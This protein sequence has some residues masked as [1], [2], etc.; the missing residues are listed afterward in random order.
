MR[1]RTLLALLPQSAV[2]LAGCSASEGDGDP[3]ETATRTET[4][5]PDTDFDASV[6]FPRG[7]VAGDPVRIEVTVSNSGGDAGDYV[8]TLTRDG[9]DLTSGSARVGPGG[10]ATITLEHAFESAGEYDVAVAGAEATLV[11]FEHSLAFVH[12]AMGDVDTL[13]IEQTVSETGQIDLGEGPTPWELTA[14][15]T[16]GKNFEAETLYTRREDDVVYGSEQIART[17]E[18]WAADGTV[19]VRRTNHT[20]ESVEYHQYPSERPLTTTAL[21]IHGT[22]TE[23]FLSVE[24]TDD[25]YVFVFDPATAEEATALASRT[26]QPGGLRPAEAATEARLE[27]RY[28]RRTGRAGTY[29]S[30]LQLTGA[31]SF[32]ELERSVTDEY[33]AYGEPVDVSVPDDVRENAG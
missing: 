16:V 23:A 22:D 5:T 18:E 14:T 7:G 32:P 12:A 17:I 31:E 9:T 33:V 27:L 8:A 19:Y 13:R 29:E 3:T 21:D 24:D 25:E 1:R 11:I 28:D 10:S 30:D 20:E 26:I 15:G 4:P 2:L 6:A